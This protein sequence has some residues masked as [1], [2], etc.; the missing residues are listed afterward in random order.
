MNSGLTELR[1]A[2]DGGAIFILMQSAYSGGK[3]TINHVI[4]PEVRSH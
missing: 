3:G 2:L 1:T 4:V